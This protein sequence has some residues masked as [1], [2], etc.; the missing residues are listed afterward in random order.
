MERRV[1]AKP[2]RTAEIERGGG[3]MPLTLDDWRLHGQERYLENA[4]L[5]R[6]TYRRPDGDWEHDHCEFCWEP[7]VE[8]GCQDEL[9]EGF[10]TPDEDR[11]ICPRC[12]EDFKEQFGWSVEE[13]I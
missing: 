1:E 11:W 13:S 5:H 4:V 8:D 10:A 3:I 6:A 9:S 12:F 7:F 2:G